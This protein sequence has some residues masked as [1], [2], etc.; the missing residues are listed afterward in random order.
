VTESV[1]DRLVRLPFYNSLTEAEQNCVIDAIHSFRF[2]TETSLSFSRAEQLPRLSRT[3]LPT[4]DHSELANGDKRE[5][6]P[7]A[8]TI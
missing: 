5:S 2:A 3:A 6:S 4:D 1:S 7:D 8:L